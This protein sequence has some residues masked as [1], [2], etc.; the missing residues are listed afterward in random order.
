MERVFFDSIA[1]TAINSIFFL[2][3]GTDILTSV[4]TEVSTYNAENIGC[5]QLKSLSDRLFL[6]TYYVII[7]TH[8]VTCNLSCLSSH[9]MNLNCD[10]LN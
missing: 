3:Y 6:I 7:V 2:R 4:A 9:F 5:M 8:W 1:T 10:K